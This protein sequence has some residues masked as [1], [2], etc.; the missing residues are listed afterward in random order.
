MKEIWKDIPE[1]EGLYQISNLGKVKSLERKVKN[2]NGY[3]IV[4]EK[5]LKNIINSKGYYIVI[6]RKN[7]K[8]DL[9]LVHRLI[10]E[11]FI[12]NPN[13]YPCIN[14]I[15]G[16]K[17]NNNIKNLEWCTYQHNIKEA[18]RLGLNKY[19]YKKN[20]NTKYWLGKK[21]K[22]HSKSKAIIQYDEHNNIIKVW[23]SIIDASREL[24]ICNIY[25]SNVCR[26]R[27]KTAGGYKW[28][29]KEEN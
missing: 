21:G 20:F 1:Y 9:R 14:H 3:R 23:D 12:P 4:K 5:I 6:L 15:D 11:N 25:I 26:G 19:T 2:K 10:G 13:N 28:K 8:N 17:Q 7:N 27:Q 29:F 22:Y 24:N 18:F 16:N